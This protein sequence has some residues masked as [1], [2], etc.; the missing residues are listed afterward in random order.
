MGMGDEIMAAGQAR[1]AASAA[2]RPALIV[3]R[4]GAPRWHP[5]WRGLDF[6]ETDPARPHV[7]VVNGSGARPYVDYTTTTADRWAYTAW[8]CT[9]GALSFVEADT[10]R[11]GDRLVF[12]DPYIKANASPNKK[13]PLEYWQRLVDLG[14]RAG[15]R[16][17]QPLY[18]KPALEGVTG[19]RSESFEAG[20]AMMAA[21]RAAVLHEGGLHHAAAAI[22]VRAVVIFGAMTDP[23]NTGYAE[24]INLWRDWP[25]G[26]GWRVP[27]PLAQKAMRDI[28]PDQ[29]MAALE[30]L[31]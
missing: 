20:V 26:R 31:E 15:W 4:H 23:R 14:R 2:G 11:L 30:C 28:R 18:G 9:P 16:F 24:H 13:W 27:N 22:G 25:D 10:A 1:A 8:R 3:D 6:I 5:L 21:C 19:V 17:L 29:V 7:R 12:V